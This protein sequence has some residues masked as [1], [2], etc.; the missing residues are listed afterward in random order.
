MYIILYYML[1]LFEIVNFYFLCKTR[2]KPLGF[3]YNACWGQLLV[4]LAGQCTRSQNV[5]CQHKVSL[6]VDGEYVDPRAL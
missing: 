2:K 1:N 4:L 3:I 6:C 5:G